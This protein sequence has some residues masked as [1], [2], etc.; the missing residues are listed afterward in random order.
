MPTTTAQPEKD[1]DISGSTGCDHDWCDGPESDTLP[2]FDCFDPSREYE[3]RG[4][5]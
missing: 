4:D 3:A 5:E 1:T 2:C